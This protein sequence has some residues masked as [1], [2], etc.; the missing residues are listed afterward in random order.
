MKGNPGLM[1]SPELINWLE[2][3]QTEEKALISRVDFLRG[4]QAV[5]VAELAL[6]GVLLISQ[7]PQN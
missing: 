1:N 5:V 6:R 2:R 7:K 4:Q 3:L